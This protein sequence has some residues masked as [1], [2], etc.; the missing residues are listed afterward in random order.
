L[1]GTVLAG[2]NVN[3]GQTGTQTI[4]L[5]NSG[6]G[7]LGITNPQITGANAA[8]FSLVGTLP[9]YAINSGGSATATIQCAPSSAGALTATLTFDTNDPANPTITYTLTCTGNAVAASGG[10]GGGGGNVWVPPQEVGP[11]GAGN[12]DPYVERLNLRPFPT[13]SPY[14]RLG[15][16]VIAYMYEGDTVEV[17]PTTPQCVGGFTW[18]HVRLVARAD[19]TPVENPPEGWAAGKIKEKLTIIGTLPANPCCNLNITENAGD[20]IFRAVDGPEGDLYGL[21]P[22]ASLTAIG[23]QPGWWLVHI[24]WFFWEPINRQGWVLSEAVVAEGACESVPVVGE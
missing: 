22:L 16:D 1:G 8:S 10:G 17:Y 12:I 14:E 24:D 3:V 18:Y 11:S 2:W 19:G 20:I 15:V 5:Q 9:P 13:G 7:I 21:E 23:R 4:N 6:D